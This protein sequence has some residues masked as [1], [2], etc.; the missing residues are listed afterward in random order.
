MAR[1][2]IRPVSNRAIPVK[3]LA[4]IYKEFSKAQMPC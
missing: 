1:V 2:M 3:T 4:T